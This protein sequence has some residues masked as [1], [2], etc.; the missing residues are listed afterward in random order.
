M[1][2]HFRH[3][4]LQYQLAVCNVVFK[5]L[6]NQPNMDS[7]LVLRFIFST[8]FFSV[9]LVKSR[10]MFYVTIIENTRCFQFDACASC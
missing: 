9:R 1:F 5:E 10:T 7:Q 3:L 6:P 8:C 4:E 2:R